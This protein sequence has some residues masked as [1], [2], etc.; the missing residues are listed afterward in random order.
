MLS[1][2]VKSLDANA[3]GAIGSHSLT[4]SDILALLLGSWLWSPFRV[5][6]DVMIQVQLV[7]HMSPG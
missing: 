6:A 3:T 7:S 5:P 1:V 4:P 2:L